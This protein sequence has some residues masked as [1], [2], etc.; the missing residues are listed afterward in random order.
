MKYLLWGDVNHAVQAVAREGRMI[1]RQGRKFNRLH[2]MRSLAP[3]IV[4]ANASRESELREELRLSGENAPHVT[5]GHRVYVAPG[6]VVFDWF[7][8]KV[9]DVVYE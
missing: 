3:D 8:N 2:T 5:L 4:V 6:D 7:E 1:E 9:Y